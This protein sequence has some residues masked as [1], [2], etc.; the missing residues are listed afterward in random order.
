ML[1]G[2]TPSEKN[3]PVSQQAAGMLPARAGVCPRTLMGLPGLGTVWGWEM[4]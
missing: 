3:T 1:G 2:G 4:G